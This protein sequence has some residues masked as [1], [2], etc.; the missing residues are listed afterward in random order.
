[1]TDKFRIDG[2]KL[3]FH[4]QRVAQWQLGKDDW[5]TAKDI[6]PIYVE[7]SPVGHCN[8]ACG[9]CGVDYVMDANKKNRVSPMI[10]PDVFA[11]RIHEMS[12]R[13][14]R[15]VM[16][17]GEGEPLLHKG[18]NRMVESALMSGVD[19]A[20]TT[21][22]VLL[23]RLETIRNMS[24]IKVSVNAGTPET[25]QAVHK[26][27]AGDWDKVWSNIAAVVARKGKCDIGVQMVLL[28]ENEHEVDAFR[29]KAEA[30]GVDYAVVKSFSQHKFSINRQYEK[31]IP[32]VPAGS[33]KLIVRR[34]SMETTAVPY[35]KCQATPFMWGYWSANGDFYSCSAY[36]LDDRFNLGNL[37][38]QTFREIWHGEKRKENW[39]YVT[40]ELDIHECRVNCRMDK[41]N[42]F[43]DELV[44][45]AH[46][47]NFI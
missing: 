33:G 6:Y 16:F 43:L 35:E 31:F 14:I 46:N 3:S 18:I 36:L 12:F 5:E 7:V 1:M 32:I 42:R 25:Y 27:K 28:P 11:D 29:A 9:F 37:N 22:G 4:P 20:F 24:W 17:A 21:N 30:A 44:K 26:A 19:V 10:D 15:S 41:A 2:E 38:R 13:G 23:D 47:A 40:G 39:R 8:H 45:G 34:D